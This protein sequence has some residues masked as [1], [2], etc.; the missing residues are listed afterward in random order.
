MLKLYC[1]G[2]ILKFI[3]QQL[4][5]VLR[6]VEKQQENKIQKNSSTETYTEDLRHLQKVE[7]VLIAV[8]LLQIGSVFILAL[9]S[10]MTTQIC[11]LL[12]LQKVG[13]VVLVER[14]HYS[15]FCS[16]LRSWKEQRLEKTSTEVTRETILSHEAHLF[17]VLSLCLVC[18]TSGGGSH[19]Q[20]LLHTKIPSIKTTRCQREE[21]QFN[22]LPN[23]EK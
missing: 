17:K 10:H 16:C 19:D 15:Q 21:L 14:P 11:L 8:E 9:F 20:M 13:K 4:L 1:V 23:T 12:C 7:L 18:S 5:F 22:L 6:G 3:S 2:F